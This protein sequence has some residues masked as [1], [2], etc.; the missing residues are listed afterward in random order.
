MCLIAHIDHYQHIIVVEHTVH[1][2]DVVVVVIKVGDLTA[3]A[4]CRVVV[5]DR[6]QLLVLVAHF[7]VG[8]PVHGNIVEEVDGFGIAHFL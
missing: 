2:Q 4:Q 1:T 7:G 8:I 6:N 5:I 3:G